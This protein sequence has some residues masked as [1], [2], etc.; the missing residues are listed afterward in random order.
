ML[1]TPHVTESPARTAA[2]I[3][4]TV[5]QRELPSVMGPA[6]GELMAALEA[7]GVTPTGPLFAH[8]LSM[9]SGLFDFEVGVPVSAPVAPAGRVQPGQL[10]A[11]RVARATYRGPYEGLHNAW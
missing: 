9:E 11:A 5:P 10:P 4:L 1:D 6:V 2:V 8:Y 3:R 7:Q